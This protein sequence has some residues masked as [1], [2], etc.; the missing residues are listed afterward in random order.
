MLAFVACP[1]KGQSLGIKINK[2]LHSMLTDAK[3]PRTAENFVN[4]QEHKTTSCTGCAQV[5]AVPE[6]RKTRAGVNTVYWPIE[7]QLPELACS[8]CILIND[9]CRSC[10]RLLIKSS[11]P[12]TQ[13]QTPLRFVE[14]E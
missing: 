6:I 4:A 8:S 1:H 14:G 5:A 2:N 11:L 3:K 13:T 10:G 12:R 9:C 7:P